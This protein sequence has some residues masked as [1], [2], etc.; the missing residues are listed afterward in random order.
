VRKAIKASSA[1]TDAAR[2]AVQERDAKTANTYASASRNLAT[3]AGI[4][5]DKAAAAHGKPTQIAAHPS[6]DE[7]KAGLEKLGLLVEDDSP[8]IDA[9]VIPSPQIESRDD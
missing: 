8:V 3:T 4:S 6:I 1:A 5:N 2:E 7:I 9:E